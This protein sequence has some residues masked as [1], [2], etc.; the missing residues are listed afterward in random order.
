MHIG[1]SALFQASGGSLTNLVQLLCEWHFNGTLA[2][3][4]VTIFAT[5]RVVLRLRQ[6]A[7]EAVLQRIDTVPFP[8]SDRSIVGRFVDEQLRLPRFLKAKEID[9]LFCPGSV[10]PYLTS[11]PV[12]PTFQNAAPF[13]DRMRPSSVGLSRWLQLALLQLCLRWSARKATAG[14]FLSN[15]FRTFFVERFGFSVDDA[16]VIR[17][18]GQGGAVPDRR[19]EALYGIRRPFIVSVSHLNPYK[20]TVELIEAF[21]IASRDIPG[22]QLVLVGM[23]Q[24]P[25]YRRRVTEAIERLGVQET[26]VMTGGV[27]HADALTLMAGCESFIFTSVCETGPTVLM[28]ALAL[29][30]A[31]GTSNV[32]PMPEV[33]QDAALLFDPY[34]PTCIATVLRQL[35]ADERLRADLRVRAAER[36]RQHGSPEDVASATLTVLEE[37]A[38][39][40]RRAISS[41][42]VRS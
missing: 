20:Q 5:P 7:G 4:K 1:I 40:R 18:A 38:A 8:A 36:A 31:I 11:V 35:M 17:R 27:P 10:V 29:G 15:W 24:F 25:A 16:Y 23:A 30:L 42:E 19:I 39:P 14:I 26:V 3:H 41:L 13:S 34:D 2:K 12:V 28:E 9:V 33:V 32:G 37:A 21:A 6:A 22:R